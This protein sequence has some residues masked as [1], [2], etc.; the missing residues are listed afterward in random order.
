MNQSKRDLSPT[1]WYEWSG[2]SVFREPFG[3]AGNCVEGSKLQTDEE[4]NQRW[5]ESFC[6][7]PS[8]VWSLG[9]TRQA[10]LLLFCLFASMFDCLFA[11]LVARSLEMCKDL[12][13]CFVRIFIKQTHELVASR[14]LHKSI[15]VLL[16]EHYVPRFC[17]Q[18]VWSWHKCML[19]CQPTP[20]TSVRSSVRNFVNDGPNSLETI[21]Q[22]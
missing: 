15:G 18:N 11:C 20:A 9:R 19:S 8:F 17:G 13:R 21:K 16:S 2:R 10:R 12:V 1:N 6:L 5:H 22:L 4:G 3:I 14:P 7:L